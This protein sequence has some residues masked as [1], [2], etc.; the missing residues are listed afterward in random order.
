M[1]RRT[2]RII[3]ELHEERIDVYM[4]LVPLWHAFLQS[5]HRRQLGMG[6]GPLTAIDVWA[7]VDIFGPEDAKGRRE[8]YYLLG[9]LDN[10][11]VEWLGKK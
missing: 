3:A 7:I 11:F 4:D 8:W 1:E 10:D 6:A 9:I 2:G 5:A